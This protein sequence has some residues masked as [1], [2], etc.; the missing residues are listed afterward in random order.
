MRLSLFASASNDATTVDYK[1][2][3]KPSDR[4]Q[5]AS[6]Q[7]NQKAALHGYINTF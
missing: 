1:T 3:N 7:V 4:I 6:S 5:R 2:L